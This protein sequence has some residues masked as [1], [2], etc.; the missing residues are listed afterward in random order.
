MEKDVFLNVDCMDYMKSMTAN[1]IDFTLTDIP[2]GEV[3]R[4]L[5]H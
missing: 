2:Y 4:K 5:V 3:G 1:S